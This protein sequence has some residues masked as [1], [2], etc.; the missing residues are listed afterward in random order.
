M[1]AVLRW[2]RWAIT[3]PL[4]SAPTPFEILDRW[5]CVIE[6]I[7]GYGLDVFRRTISSFPGYWNLGW[8]IVA[9][10]RWWTAQRVEPVMSSQDD[11]RGISAAQENVA[12]AQPEANLSATIP[13]SPSPAKD[14]T[15]ETV[16]MNEVKKDDYVNSLPYVG[17]AVKVWRVQKRMSQGEMARSLSRVTGKNV[18]Q[19]ALSK[20]ESGS[21]HPTVGR[22]AACA[23]VLGCRVSKI[24]ELAEFMAINDR[25]DPKEIAIEVV[26]A[27]E[28]ELG[29]REQYTT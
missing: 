27:C 21:T 8:L 26:E 5:E 4:H 24:F 11:Y 6:G 14:A 9:I 28:K 25:R 17:T 29:R 19:S 22:I 23:K 10:S 16:T 20:L 15:E 12:A 13:V 18:S 1:Y 3:E 7:V 2:H